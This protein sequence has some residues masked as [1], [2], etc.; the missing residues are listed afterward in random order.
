M[1]LATRLVRQVGK[2]TASTRPKACPASGTPPGRTTPGELFGRP[3]RRGSSPRF[4]LRSCG[5]LGHPHN[6]EIRPLGRESLIAKSKSQKYF[7]NSWPTVPSIAWGCPGGH[8]PFG[9]QSRGS[10]DALMCERDP[11]YTVR[12][13]RPFPYSTKPEKWVVRAGWRVN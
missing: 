8:G 4:P 9:L 6:M 10:F 12:N 11:R 2:T 3:A 13:A 1:E 5:D 7:A